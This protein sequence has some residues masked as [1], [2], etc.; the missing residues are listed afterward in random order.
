[1]TRNACV[2]LAGFALAL[3]VFS[4]G[5]GP[6]FADQER[7]SFEGT[8]D[9]SSGGTDT[10]RAE[11]VPD[12]E[13][14]WK[15]TF[16]FRFDNRN[17]TWRGTAEGRLEEGVEIT[18][19]ASWRSRNWTWRAAIEDGVMVGEHTEIRSRGR[20]RSTGTFELQVE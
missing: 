12:G 18:G 1:M 3:V 5:I 7:R 10:L 6:A 2:G 20:T 4:A 9:W 14:S 15:V 19:T 17:N 8:Y 16:R 11:F 13:N